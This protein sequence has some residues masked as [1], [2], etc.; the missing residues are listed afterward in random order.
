MRSI[1]RGLS[2]STNCVNLDDF[3]E[4]YSTRADADSIFVGVSIT[5]QL[6]SID[7][8]CG[9]VFTLANKRP[10]LAG[11]CVIRE[12]LVD[13]NNPHGR[14]G[15]RLRV[16]RLGPESR[17]VFSALSSPIARACMA[18]ARDLDT[19]TEARIMIVPEGL[20]D[21][22]RSILR[23]GLSLRRRGPASPSIEQ[24]STDLKRSET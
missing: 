2:I 20:V 6:R 23:S 12:L 16:T 5:P 13:A 15:L 8:E 17:R 4:R 10:V 7:G 19:P 9:F 22:V 14:E 11:T 24:T 3:I 21:L 18:A 1:V